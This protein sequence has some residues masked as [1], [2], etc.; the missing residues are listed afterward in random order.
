[1]SFLVNH[2]ILFTGDTLTVQN[3]KIKPFFWLQNMNSKLQKKSIE[4]L[5]EFDNIEMIC[6][7]HTGYLKI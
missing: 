6:T 1:M 5:L 3:G 7:G 4:K 2:K